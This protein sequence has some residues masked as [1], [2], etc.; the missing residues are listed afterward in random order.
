M[1]WFT[2]GGES[3]L[4][5]V[6]NVVFV[7]GTAVLM[8]RIKEVAPPGRCVACESVAIEQCS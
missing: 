6:I 3:L 2:S 4:L 5:A 7:T 1:F 8:F